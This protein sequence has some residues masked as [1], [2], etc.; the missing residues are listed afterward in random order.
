MDDEDEREHLEATGAP[1]PRRSA[2]AARARAGAT[3]AAR[4]S[5]AEVWGLRVLAG[6]FV[7]VLLLAFLL[8]LISVA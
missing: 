3:V 4:R 1:L 5:P 7:V 2:A 6:L 8:V